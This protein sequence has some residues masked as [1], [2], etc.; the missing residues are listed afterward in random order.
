M[1]REHGAQDGWL[2]KA[3]AEQPFGRLIDP[4][5]VA[6]ACAFLA[7][8]ESGLMTGAIIDFDQSV[9]GCYESA[10]HPTMRVGP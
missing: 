5:E 8:A 10:P 3:A 7:T 6:R 2:E 4:A 1:R 9:V